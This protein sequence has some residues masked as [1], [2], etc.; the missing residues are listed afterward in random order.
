MI[1]RLPSTGG[2]RAMVWLGA[3]AYFAAALAWL[4][5]GSPLGESVFP[6]GSAFDTSPTG[7]SLARRYL[8]G[9]V[10][11]PG[12]PVR[13]G[14]LTRA[15]GAQLEPAAVVV[16]VRPGHAPG[17]L[18]M[19]GAERRFV[20]EG[21]R[22]VLGLRD[23]Y[24]PVR[25]APAAGRT[26]KVFPAWPGVGAL[27][28]PVPRTLPAGLPAEAHSVFAIGSAPAVARAPIGRGELVVMAVPEAIEN[29]GLDQADHLRLLEALAGGGRPVYFDES[30]H[31]IEGR[32]GVIDLL[33]AWGFGPVLVLLP[34]TGL[35][36]LWRERARLGLA[37]DDHRER[38]SDAVDLLDS[39]AL[40]Y[41]RSLG[42]AEVRA[43]LKAGGSRSTPG[44]RPHATR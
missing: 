12:G 27:R 5:S 41:A 34:V 14:V 36:I 28:P 32:P 9:R 3:L 37:L 4:G 8:E 24:G 38:R 17:A 18:L 31:G 25:V 23:T 13:V 35:A 6:P 22:L 21:G 33:A 2:A 10:G 1:D 15:V 40:L 39:L 26:A 7:L 42:R 16:R 20:S 43:L 30:V 29:G 44:S 19:S 11:R